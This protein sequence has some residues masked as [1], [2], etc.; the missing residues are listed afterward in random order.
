MKMQHHM[1]FLFQFIIDF[2]LP[3]QNERWGKEW[4]QQSTRQANILK[5]MRNKIRNRGRQ[6]HSFR[7][8]NEMLNNSQ[9][10]NLSIQELNFK[11]NFSLLNKKKNDEKIP[12]EERNIKNDILL[13]SCYCCSYLLCYP[14]HLYISLSLNYD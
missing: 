2:V 10:S 13:L 12:D 4:T 11:S 5:T 3:F 8:K 9:S 14:L 7:R 1:Q 6:S